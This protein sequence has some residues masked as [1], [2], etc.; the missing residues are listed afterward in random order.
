MIYLRCNTC[1]CDVQFLGHAIHVQDGNYYYYFIAR[2]YIFIFPSLFYCLFLER[3]LLLKRCNFSITK[4]KEEQ[5]PFY[6]F[7]NIW[8]L[9]KCL[10]GLIFRGNYN[11]TTS[12][13]S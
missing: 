3:L 1:L 10:K 4:K 11:L 12:Y 9:N 2:Y 6:S 13:S 5:I 7:P 8:Q